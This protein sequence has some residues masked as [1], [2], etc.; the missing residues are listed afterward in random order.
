MMNII[1]I[2]RREVVTV[3]KEKK[4]RKVKIIYGHEKIKDCLIRVAKNKK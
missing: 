2:K 4:Y 3:K 1:K